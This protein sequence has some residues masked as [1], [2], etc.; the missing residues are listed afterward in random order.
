LPLA[1]ALGALVAF[2]RKELHRA[3]VTAFV[4]SI[5]IVAAT[6]VLGTPQ[7]LYSDG[8]KHIAATLL[9]RDDI[10]KLVVVHSGLPHDSLTPRLAYYTKGWTSGWLEGKSS[11]KL[12]WTDDGLAG[13][14]TAM[15]SNNTAIVLERERD[16]F[17]RP[18][19]MDIPEYPLVIDRLKQ[20]YRHHDS[21]RS[22]D[23]F[24]N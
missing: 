8:A 7:D 9:P 22:Y 13:K 17:A 20:T 14:L 10:N 23:L 12:G 3:V 5:V 1:F 19:E 4:G 6:R 18:I 24:Y 2:Q 21:L 16:R 15:A 11:Y